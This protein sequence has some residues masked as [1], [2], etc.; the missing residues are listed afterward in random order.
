MGYTDDYEL[1]QEPFYSSTA[2]M[3]EADN[4]DDEMGEVVVGNGTGTEELLS[5]HI[6]WV[7]SQEQAQELV[8]SDAVSLEE[9]LGVNLRLELGEGG[10][11]ER[12]AIVIEGKEGAFKYECR[13]RW[14]FAKVGSIYSTY[15]T[16]T[17]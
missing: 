8:A 5:A 15:S 11:P 2:G 10:W 14:L 3:A 16:G 4:Q 7:E 17:R 13:A 12:P 9:P 1:L 6:L